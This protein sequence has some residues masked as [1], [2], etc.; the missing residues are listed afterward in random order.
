MDIGQKKGANTDA[1]PA[2]P[3]LAFT[4]SND[5]HIMLITE[6]PN[7]STLTNSFIIDGSFYR[8]S[9]CVY[10]SLNP[11]ENSR[12]SSFITDLIKGPFII[13]NSLQII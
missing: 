5:S 1:T 3:V 10:K 9:M 4:Q 12:N 6:L 7:T 13:P 2:L 11:M 8:P